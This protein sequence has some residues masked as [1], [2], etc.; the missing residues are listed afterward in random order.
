MIVT[1][2]SD[3]SC[4]VMEEEKNSEDY[5][6]RRMDEPI[7]T[8]LDASSHIYTSPSVGASV[9]PSVRPSVRRSVR[10]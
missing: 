3:F 10:W 9:G 5:E 6:G 2:V 1:E 7:S 4:K 8:F